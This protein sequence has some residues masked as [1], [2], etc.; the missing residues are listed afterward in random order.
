MQGRAGQGKRVRARVA[1]GWWSPGRVMLAVVIG[2]VLTLA[3]TVHTAA[4]RAFAADSNTLYINST[5]FG[6]A[7]TCV[8][9]DDSYDPTGAANT[10]TLGG[11]LTKA[12][13]SATP[14][15]VTLA[16][17]FAASIPD[18]TQAMITPVAPSTNWMN[19]T[20]ANY[21][22][23]L[24]AFYAATAP[25]TID[26]QN[27]LGIQAVSTLPYTSILLSG[28]NITLRN[29]S[30]IRNAGSA[31]V[32]AE[33][34]SNLVI[35]GGKT[36]PMDNNLTQRF[37]EIDANVN[38]LIFRNYT[39]GNLN[40]GGVGTRAAAVLITQGASSVV[41]TNITIDSVTF[42]TTRDPYS[43][44]W[45][46]TATNSSECVNNSIVLA[47]ARFNGLDIRNCLFKNLVK[48]PT[49]KDPVVFSIDLLNSTAIMQALNFHDNTIVNSGSCKTQ[50]GANDTFCSLIS[51]PGSFPATADT[52]IQNNTF[53]N[54]PALGIPA[55]ITW[56][57]AQTTTP[58]TATKVHIQ[59]NYFDGFQKSTI[60]LYNA[61]VV[62]MERNTFG[63]HT[64]SNGNTVTEETVSVGTQGTGA[65]MIVNEGQTTNK[66]I[67][68]WRPDTVSLDPSSCDVTINALATAPVSPGTA[69]TLPLRLDAYWTPTNKAE[70]Y[71]GS[72][73]VSSGTSA[74]LT[75]A[76]PQEAFAPDGSL[77]GGVRLQTQALEA[78]QTVS[79]QYSRVASLQG[80]TS[81]NCGTPT[82]IEL[83]SQAGSVQGGETVTLTG[84]GFKALAASG[85]LAVRFNGDADCDRLTVVD[86]NTITCVVPQSTR[87]GSRTGV[88]DVVVLLD[89]AVIA[90]LPDAYIYKADG[91]LKVEKR[92]WVD[93]PDGLTGAE[94]HDAL[95]GSD[96]HGATELQSGEV[97]RPGTSIAWTYTVTY[98]YTTGGRPG[99]GSTDVALMVVD[100][101]DDHLGLVCQIPVLYLNTPVGC[102]ATEVVLEP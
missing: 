58:A 37:L 12:N 99:G 53:I 52:M 65:G 64:F 88:V 102:A 5:A 26:L 31:I 27:K 44:T 22:K 60:W 4:S 29:A 49:K 62:T 16:T 63:P 72:Q 28:A 86:D 69:P 14:L 98:V 48:S 80:L 66:K 95:T 43:T 17:D 75:V 71:I 1:A 30:E 18:G 25:M 15:T 54:D 34:A 83:T 35:E 77:L 101:V 3:E 94:L 41:D 23:Q 10:C 79:S 59:D 100:V 21:G 93:I 42:T 51:L 74:K 13:A 33:G 85:N 6:K 46:C 56:Y 81:S 38:G 61:G 36:M 8:L 24:G 97:V 76:L 73:T 9:G 50:N 70:K 87:A 20:H 89:D 84:S 11:A 96:H 19:T 57:G 39:V 47:G 7:G 90:T 92:A 91:T 68:T 78:A 40:D 55:A 32:A 2:V 82:T 67:A 45:T